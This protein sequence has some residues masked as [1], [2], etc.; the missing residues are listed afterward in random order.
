MTI[1]VIGASAGIGLQAVQQGLERE[2]TLRALASHSTYSAKYFGKE[3]GITIYSFINAIHDL[4]Y[5]TAF[6]AS[7]RE[8]WYVI[9]GL[10]H[11]DAVRSQ[12]HSTD[13][14]GA[15]DPVFSV[16]Y[17]LGI[18]FQPRLADL[19]RQK[20]HGMAGVSMSHST[21]YQLAIGEEMDE[22]VM[23]KQRGRI[24]RLEVTSNHAT[25]PIS[26]RKR[27]K[28]FTGQ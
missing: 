24:L 15:T 6:S 8:A 17:L 9:D 10:M 26:N 22:A 13:S 20:L 11:N 3:K 23:A 2:H 12:I 28:A 14:H 18:D 5:S 7:D 4:F 25:A 19:Y 1:A 27:L 16:S 21:D